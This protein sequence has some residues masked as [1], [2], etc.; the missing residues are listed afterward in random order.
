MHDYIYKSLLCYK[1]IQSEVVAVGSRPPPKP[2]PPNFRYIF[3]PVKPSQCA[4]IALR[5]ARGNFIVFPLSDDEIFCNDFV[6][7]LYEYINKFDTNKYFF[8]ARH[9]YRGKIRDKGMKLNRSCKSSPGLGLCYCVSSAIIKKIGSIDRR[10]V[11]AHYDADYRMRLSEMGLELMLMTGCI[12]EERC[13]RSYDTHGIYFPNS[14]KIYG[15]EDQKTLFSFWVN[16]DNST[17]CSRLLPVDSFSDDNL[18]DVSQ[19]RNIKIN[20][21]K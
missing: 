17:A 4:E 18:L 1:N 5:S 9:K 15:K 7:I 12:L 14:W 3:A 16:Q 21:W 8:G 19:G 6:P 13:D 11:V 2:M 20:R 10:F